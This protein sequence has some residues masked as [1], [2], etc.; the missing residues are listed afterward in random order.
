MDLSLV[1]SWISLVTKLKRLRCRGNSEAGD[2][3]AEKIN[4]LNADIE[5][6]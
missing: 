6:K 5:N 4:G 2:K 1:T 3:L